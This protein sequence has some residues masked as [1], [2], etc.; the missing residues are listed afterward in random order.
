MD[1][2]ERLFRKWDRTSEIF[3]L[4]AWAES[5]AIERPVSTYEVM[6]YHQLACTVSSSPE[7][8]AVDLLDLDLMRI[9]GIHTHRVLTQNHACQAPN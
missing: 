1:W 7:Q 9:P 8:L 2:L 3:D 4:H 6:Q 5:I